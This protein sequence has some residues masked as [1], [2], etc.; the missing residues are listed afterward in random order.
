[1]VDPLTFKNVIW[2]IMQYDMYDCVTIVHMYHC[3]IVVHWP[4]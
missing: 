1:M 2:M 4:A 3:N